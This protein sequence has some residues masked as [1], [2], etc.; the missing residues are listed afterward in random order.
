M[1]T[2]LV[3]HAPQ[4]GQEPKQLVIRSAVWDRGDSAPGRLG[5]ARYKCRLG[6]ISAERGQCQEAPILTDAR[7]SGYQS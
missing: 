6:C 3:K 1:A 7:K 4:L 5:L 2:V